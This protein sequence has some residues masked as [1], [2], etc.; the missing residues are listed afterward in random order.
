MSYCLLHRP[1]SSTDCS[2]TDRS[3]TDRFALSYCANC[4]LFTI[5]TTVTITA[6]TATT[7]AAAAATAATAATAIVIS[8]LQL[9]WLPLVGRTL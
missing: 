3:T 7:T 4:L 9:F 8:G 6:V 1:S 2:I 5:T